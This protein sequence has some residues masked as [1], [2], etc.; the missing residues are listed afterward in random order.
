VE[1][2]TRTLAVYISTWDP[3]MSK[4]YTNQILGKIS[5][6]NCSCQFSFVLSLFLSFVFEDVGTSLE[7][8]GFRVIFFGWE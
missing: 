2:N 4:L 3:I 7:K 1:A 8:S 6:V 5:M